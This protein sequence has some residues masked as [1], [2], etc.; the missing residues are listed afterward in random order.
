MES[1][2]I[3]QLSSVASYVIEGSLLEMSLKEDGG[4]MVFIKVQ[5]K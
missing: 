3:D 5:G 2:Y 4:V 1:D